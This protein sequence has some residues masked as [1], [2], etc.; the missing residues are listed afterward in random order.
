[1]VKMKT[2]KSVKN[3]IFF[4]ALFEQ[5]SDGI[6]LYDKKGKAFSF[7]NAFARM[8]GYSLEEMLALGVNEL[9]VE[10]LV[11]SPQLFACLMSGEV[12]NFEVEHS[13]KCG[14]LFQLEVTANL[15][16]AGNDQL[17]IAVHRDITERVRTEEALRKNEAKM[18][19]MVENIVDVIAIINRDGIIRYESPNVEKWFGWRPEELVNEVAWNNI[20]PD[21][22]KNMLNLFAALLVKTNAVVTTECRFLCKD[23]S[24]KWIEFTAFNGLHDPDIVGVLASYHDITDSKLAKQALSE[25]ERLLRESQKAAHIGSYATDLI[26]RTWKSSPEIAEI[27]GIDDTYP[28]TMEGWAALIHPDSRARLSESQLQVE[29]EKK[30][31]DHVYRIIRVNDGEERWVHGLG[32]LEYDQQLNPVRLIGTIQD[33]T[34]RMLVQRELAAS[35]ARYRRITEGLTD[36]QYTVRVENGCAVETKQSSACATVTGY[37]PEE[38]AA[39]P[40][41]WF[42]IVVAEDREDVREKVRQTLAGEEVLPIE[43]RIIRKDGV[44]RWISDTMILF[45]NAAGKL[46]SYDG[47]IKDITERKQAKL[48]LQEKNAELE[49][50]S[51]TVSHDLKSPLITIQSYVGMILKDMAAGNYVRAQNDLKR[52][53]GAAGKMTDLLNDLLELSRVG[54]VMSS[55]SRIDMNCLVTDTLEQLS[56]QLGQ[57]KIEVSVSQSLPDAFG[58]RNRIAEVVQNLVENALKYMGDQAEPRIEIGT[59]PDD[60]EP[61]FFVQD[62]GIGIDPCFQE[63][64]F[65][66]FN[67]LDAKSEGTGV[68]LAL[69]KR[70]IEVHGGRVW[71]ESAGAGKG[72]CFCFTLP[73]TRQ[74]SVQKLPFYTTENSR[75]EAQQSV[76]YGL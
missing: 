75:L 5:S 42:N 50:F 63:N 2:G 70:I 57:Q 52:I 18:R 55:S 38:F 22:R 8:Y 51:Y 40:H 73:E 35:E 68:G 14:H 10:A 74:S 72:A 67:K 21:D 48:D 46:L 47:V 31:F 44:M 32:E 65:G 17:I 59:R 41:L 25:N 16:T 11:P 66:L 4:R 39:D 26:A 36:Y 6:I 7:N 20:H 76:G 1:M 34:E 60:K 12:I 29:A 49:R 53:E 54:R 28:R 27:F 43:H 45:K 61:L 9:N 58:D 56:G 62:N 33:V 19:A 24:Y 15:I 37:T 64:I 30:R 3:Q 69:V 23:C 13:H 71:V